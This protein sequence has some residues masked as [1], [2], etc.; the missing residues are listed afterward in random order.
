MRNWI[1]TSVV[2][3]IISIPIIIWGVDKYISN[4]DNRLRNEFNNGIQSVFKNREYI[5]IV[6]SGKKVSYEPK[7]IPNKPAKRNIP[8]DE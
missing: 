7:S 6:Y 5:D 1:F 4:K 2:L 8:Q 3:W